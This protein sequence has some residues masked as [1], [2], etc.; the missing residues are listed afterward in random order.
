M[1][2]FLGRSCSNASNGKTQKRQFAPKKVWCC[3]TGIQKAQGGLA[4]VIAGG[5]SCCLALDP[6]GSQMRAEICLYLFANL[7]FVKLYK[8]MVNMDILL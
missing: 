1:L 6:V 8:Q 4:K 5:L 2:S 3:T 7:D